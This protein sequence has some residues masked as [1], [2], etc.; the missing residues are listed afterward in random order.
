M[1]DVVI[2]EL[3]H[4]AIHW[5]KQQDFWYVHSYHHLYYCS[6]DEKKFKNKR[7]KRKKEVKCE[8]CWVEWMSEE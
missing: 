2:T 8:I 6:S 4:S 3:D 1:H 5:Y 7:S